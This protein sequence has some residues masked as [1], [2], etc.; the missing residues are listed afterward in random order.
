MGS[1]GATSTG[2]IGGSTF[3]GTAST[4]TGGSMG[5]TGGLFVVTLSGA[6][7]PCTTCGQGE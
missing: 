3:S 4:I 1:R 6:G 7:K 5:G 2:G